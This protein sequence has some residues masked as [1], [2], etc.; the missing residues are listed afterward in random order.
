MGDFFSGAVIMEGNNQECTGCK[1]R[2]YDGE[3][4]IILRILNYSEF[5]RRSQCE[6]F[7][8]FFFPL[9]LSASGQNNPW[10]LEQK[11]IASNQLYMRPSFGSESVP[12]RVQ[13]ADISR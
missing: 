6:F 9:E 1:K 5:L 2:V 3:T 11:R 12:P 10:D 8:R 4:E 7:D 13:G